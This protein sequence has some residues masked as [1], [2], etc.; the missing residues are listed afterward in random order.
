MVVLG[1]KEGERIVI[2]QSI[3]IT[4]IEMDG[5]RVRLDIEAPDG[6]PIYREEVFRRL[7]T[8][9]ND[10]TINGDGESRF[11]VESN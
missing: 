3:T 4:V 8:G 1:R 5:K 10:Q 2:G 11:L 7:A 6:T 9:L